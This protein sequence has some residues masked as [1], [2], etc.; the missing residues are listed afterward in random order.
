MLNKRLREEPI[1]YLVE[2]GTINI[3]EVNAIHKARKILKEIV[4]ARIQQPDLPYGDIKHHLWIHGPTGT[5]KSRKAQAL[6]P[7][8]YKKRKTTW[9]SNYD[10]AKPAHEAVIIEEWGPKDSHLL[11]EL[12]VWADVYPFPAE[13][14]SIPSPILTTIL[15]LC[16]PDGFL[17]LD[18]LGETRALQCS[19]CRSRS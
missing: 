7:N 16:L 2:D 15:S 5:G 18:L 4:D 8:A 6:Y 17:G 1:D 9:W 10:K 12:K 13:V 14:M 11:D 3:K 19:T